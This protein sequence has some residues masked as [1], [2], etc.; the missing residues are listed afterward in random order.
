LPLDRESK[1]FSDWSFSLFALT[2]CAAR[3]AAIRAAIARPRS[4]RRM[5]PQRQICCGAMKPHA[6]KP[7]RITSGTT[8]ASACGA[9]V[10]DVAVSP[11]NA[12]A[13]SG[14]LGCPA[15]RVWMCYT[16]I[17]PTGNTTCP[18]E[19]CEPSRSRLLRSASATTHLPP[20]VDGRAT[21]RRRIT[22]QFGRDPKTCPKHPRV[23]RGG[24]KEPL[25][26]S[27]PTAIPMPIR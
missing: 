17:A 9:N 1:R 20:T 11:A 15:M 23:Q 12:S 5:R 2:P 27:R 14:R 8:A 10:S 16:D 6:L 22:D 13:I 4:A 24:N 25:G 18:L 26:P 21:R 3:S 7:H 19:Y